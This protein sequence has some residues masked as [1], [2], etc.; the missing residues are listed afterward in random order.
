MGLGGGSGKTLAC[1]MGGGSLCGRWKKC[2]LF[3]GRGHVVGHLY[4]ACF[5]F[6]AGSGPASSPLVTFER[7]QACKHGLRKSHGNSNSFLTQG[8]LLLASLLTL[9]VFAKSSEDLDAPCESKCGRQ[10]DGSC[11][12]IGGWV[13][14]YELARSDMRKSVQQRAGCLH[15]RDGADQ[16][17]AGD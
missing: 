2:R 10:M 9:A 3:W 12:R 13:R 8:P 4:V 16:E 6:F 11:G 17:S 1:V 5:R 15:K 7:R 14:L